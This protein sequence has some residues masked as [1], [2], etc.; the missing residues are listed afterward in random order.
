MPVEH[1]I[2]VH[3]KRAAPRPPHIQLDPIGPQGQSQPKGLGRV[4]PRSLRGP[5][6]GEYERP[7]HA[8]QCSARIGPTGRAARPGEQLGPDPS[9]P[10]LSP[11]ARVC[12]RVLVHWYGAGAERCRLVAVEPASL[13]RCQDNLARNIAGA[14]HHVFVRGVNR[15]VVAVDSLDYDHTLFLLERS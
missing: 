15:T 13:S 14:V 8:P 9:S 11:G 6:M 12:P 1:E 7:S 5:S 4:L 10:G 2:V 3:D